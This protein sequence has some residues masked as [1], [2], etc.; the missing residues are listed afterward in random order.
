[1]QFIT[2]RPPLFSIRNK[3]KQKL[4]KPQ[5]ESNDGDGSNF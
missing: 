4:I 3:V 2:S 5:S 1:M